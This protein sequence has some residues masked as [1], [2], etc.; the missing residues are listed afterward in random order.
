MNPVKKMYIATAGALAC[1]FLF[2]IANSSRSIGF[3]VNSYFPCAQDP[4][5]SF[6]CYG[7]IDV[8]VM[9]ITAVLFTV[10]TSIIVFNLYKQLKSK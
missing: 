3:F 8:G 5:N 1:V 10:C 9:M 2:L 7:W 4:R 6:P